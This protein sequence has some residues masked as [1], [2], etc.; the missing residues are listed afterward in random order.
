MQ[1][2]NDSRPEDILIDR[3][4]PGATSTQRE[5]ARQNVR[6]LVTVLVRIN[7]RLALE[8]RGKTDSP[9]S[10]G[11]GRVAIPAPELDI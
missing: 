4:M 1:N 10:A 2:K 9:E 11:S 8:E 6:D 7:A 3:Y 5:E